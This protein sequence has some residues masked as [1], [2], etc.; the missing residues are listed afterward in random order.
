[1]LGQCSHRGRNLYAPISTFGAIINLT[2]SAI[3]ADANSYSF[4]SCRHISIYKRNR[5]ISGNLENI[6]QINISITLGED[7]AEIQDLY[8]RKRQTD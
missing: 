8:G 4:P 7:D 1:M 2:C 6:F 3:P 5:Q